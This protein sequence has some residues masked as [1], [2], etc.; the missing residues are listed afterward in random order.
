MLLTNLTTVI[1]LQIRIKLNKLYYL[2]YFFLLGISP[3]TSPSISETA[4]HSR[5]P[6]SNSS[7]YPPKS[8]PEKPN[9]SRFT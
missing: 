2:N 5:N 8:S 4:P 7:A 1:N 3:S 6:H 9:S